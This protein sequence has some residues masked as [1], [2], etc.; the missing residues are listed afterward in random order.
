[1]LP[2]MAAT[3]PPLQP[4]QA[5]EF[6]VTGRWSPFLSESLVPWIWKVEGWGKAEEVCRVREETPEPLPMT[7]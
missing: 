7:G 2:S 4:T 6:L 3:W 5:Q 1:M